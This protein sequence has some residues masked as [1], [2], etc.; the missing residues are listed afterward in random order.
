MDLI[1]AISRGFNVDPLWF[2]ILG[3]LSMH[4]CNIILC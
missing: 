1:R 3:W 2:A 4:T